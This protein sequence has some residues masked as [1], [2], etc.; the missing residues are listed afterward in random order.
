MTR[1]RSLILLEPFCIFMQKKGWHQTWGDED[2]CCFDKQNK[3][4]VAEFH[5]MR[6]EYITNLEVWIDDR[7]VDTFEV[8]FDTSNKEI[9][10]FIRKYDGDAIKASANRVYEN[11]I[12]RFW[13]EDFEDCKDVND[14]IDFL[15]DHGY[16]IDGDT[17]GAARWLWDDLN[18]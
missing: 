15:E 4:I 9:I 6:K 13:R 10:D 17:Y 7:L 2:T 5:L 18:S 8:Y 3:Q 16:P 11:I 12:H 14:V 1:K